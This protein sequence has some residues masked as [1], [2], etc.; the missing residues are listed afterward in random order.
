MRALP[1]TVA[2]PWFWQE[3]VDGSEPPDRTPAGTGH[4]ARADA[5]TAAL[6]VPPRVIYLVGTIFSLFA[7]AVSWLFTV[8]T[9]AS[10]WTLQLDPSADWRYVISMNLIYWNGWA[11]LTPPILVYAARFPLDRPMWRRALPWHVAGGLLFVGCHTLIVATGR[12]W[13]QSHFGMNVS[14]SRTVTEAYLRTLDWELTYYWAVVALGHA[15]TYSRLAREFETALEETRLADPPA[16]SAAFGR[17]PQRLLVR[18]PQG[19]AIVAVE[20]VGYIEAA[21]N[22]ACLHAGGETH[23]VRESL[24]SLEAR[25]APAGFLRLHRAAIVNLDYVKALESTQGKD[26]VV[27]LRDGTRIAAT[28]QI[29][30]RLKAA[31]MS[32]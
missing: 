6:P 26:P 3:R 10:L 18:T 14:W 31:L 30:Q 16:S 8:M 29:E 7:A 20:E 19:T 5:L 17:A 11:L 32:R 13:L 24:K 23:V 15:V 27:V 4:V 2:W 1:L 12:A 21:G 28:R 25:L 22:Y 9:G